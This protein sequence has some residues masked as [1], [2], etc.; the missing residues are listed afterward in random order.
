MIKRGN[1]SIRKILAIPQLFIL[2]LS[3]FAVSFI[4]SQASFV[5]A[6]GE[7]YGPPVAITPTGTPYTYKLPLIETKF[8]GGFAHLAEG[9]VCALVVVGAIK[10]VGSLAGLDDTT[11]NALSFAAVGGIM[12]YKGILAAVEEG[13]LAKDGFIGSN[14]GL[15][16]IGIGVAIFILMYK[17]EKKKLITFQCLPF[18]PMIGGA[19][20][21]ECNKYPFRPC[22]EYRCKSLGQACQLL[23]VGSKEEKCAW[24]NPKDVNSPTIEADKNVLNKDMTYIPDKAIRPPHRGVRIIKQLTPN[25]CLP[26]FTPLKFGVTTNEPAQCKIDYTR[27]TATGKNGFDAMQFYVGD[28]NYFLYN[29]SQEMR[30][31]APVTASGEEASAPTLENG[32]TFYLYIRCMDA[33]GNVNEDDFAIGFCVDPSPDTTPPIIESSSLVTGSPVQYNAENV[34]IEIYVNEPAECKW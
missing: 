23:N 2:I 11:T 7:Q 31:P 28:N 4:F 32:G 8:T 26:A 30:L 20:C 13:F 27:P 14:A 29:H 19:K 12:S 17:K 10:L 33:N 15:I 24:V 6:P 9:A 1:L 34:P 25:G 5:S 3:M 16:G 22:S 21:E 18:E